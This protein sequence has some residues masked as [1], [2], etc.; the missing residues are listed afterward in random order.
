MS[1]IGI[2]IVPAIVILVVL[3][4]ARSS[5]RTSRLT[6]DG[7]GDNREHVFRIKPAVRVLMAI[8]PLC[9]VFFVASAALF[10]NPEYLDWVIFGAPGAAW[11]V[12]FTFLAVKF[13][14]ARV[15][16]GPARVQ[17]FWPGV[18][19]ELPYDEI[20]SVARVG[21]G[22][23]ILEPYSGK[24]IE[25]LPFFENSY[26]IWKLISERLPSRKGDPH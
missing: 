14:S 18:R 7:H 11:A 5:G 4:L 24:K 1:S 6:V 9:G 20:K 16:V 23:V 19:F 13:S 12:G 21:L 17:G 26:D 10:P 2:L 25:I 8:S 22:N 15:R 3:W